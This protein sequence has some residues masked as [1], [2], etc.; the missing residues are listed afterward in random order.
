[1]VTRG[2][3]KHNSIA[4]ES[5]QGAI[6]DRLAVQIADLVGTEEPEGTEPVID[7]G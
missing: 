2:R 7:R 1:M 6:R 3:T 4:H 5:S